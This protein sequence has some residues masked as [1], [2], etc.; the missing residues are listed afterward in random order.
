[1][2]REHR[3]DAL[4]A[5]R[6]GGSWRRS[7]RGTAAVAF[8]AA[9]LCGAPAAAQTLRVLVT[10]D[11]GYTAPGLNAVVTALVA[12]P[13]LAVTVI[14]PETNSSGTGESRTSGPLGVYAGTTAGG[15]PCTVVQGFPADAALFGLLEQMAAA[16]PDLVVSGINNGQNLTA[17]VTAISGTVGAATWAARHGVPAVALSAGLGAP[18]Q[19]AN[20]ATYAANL[21]ELIRT[22]PGFRKKL[23]EKD[24]PRRGL[25]LNVNFPTCASGAVRGVRLVPVGRFTTFTG[26]TLL[27]SGGGI[28][29]WQP[30]TAVASPF[31][32]D[33]TSTLADPAT[34][35]AAFT[36]G[37]ATVTP[38]DPERNVSGRKLTQFKLATKLPF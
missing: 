28:D 31:V 4:R 14:A 5:V 1:M 22:K 10:N 9:W 7:A 6:G 15:Y 26:Y 25:V 35:V 30:A 32:V 33:C 2:T 37:F 38:L 27:G 24:P 3:G 34:D 8:A 18:T 20:A 23:F 13:N 36:N 19:Y 21:V 12:N 29:T 17:E 11:D 16:P